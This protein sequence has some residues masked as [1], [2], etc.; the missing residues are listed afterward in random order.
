MGVMDIE[1]YR[2]IDN[3]VFSVP[4]IETSNGYL[5]T[6]TGVQKTINDVREMIVYGLAFL[7]DVGVDELRLTDETI[8]LKISCEFGVREQMAVGIGNVSLDEF[9]QM[10]YRS[11]MRSWLPDPYQ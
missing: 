1:L 7:A 9:A 5:E 11:M 2:G 6:E 8:H 10:I 3:L 4:V